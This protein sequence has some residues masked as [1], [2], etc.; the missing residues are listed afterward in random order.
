MDNI[1][2]ESK[3]GKGAVPDYIFP[4]DAKW[5]DIAIA[6]GSAP[7]DWTAGIDIEANLASVLNNPSFKLP[8]KNQ[9][10][11]GS[12]GGQAWSQYSGV[13]EAFF[14]KTFEERSAKYIYSQT[15][16]SPDGGSNGRDNSNICINQG[17]SVEV[18]CPS[19]D[20]GQ[21]PSE[22]YME[23]P[24]DITQVARTD[25]STD[26]ELSAAV[27][28]SENIDSVA[29]AIR[30]NYGCVLGVAGTNNGTWLSSF[31]QPPNTTDVL[32]GHWLYAGKAKMIDGKKYIGVINSWG[33]DVGENGW[34]WLGEEYFN[35][36]DIFNVWTMV[37]NE[38]SSMQFK[39]DFLVNLKMGDKSSE[40]S[41]LQEAL[42]IDGE[43][44]VNP[45]GFYGEITRQS[46]LAF[47][48]KYEINSQGTNGTVVGPHTRQ[49]LNE[50]FNK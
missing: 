48:K 6:R 18:L 44:T 13:L 50:I 43:F 36:T 32:W 5:E 23:R 30:D 37:F 38:K 10:G 9:N 19:Y 33:A 2:D 14:D 22:S 27:V 8:V 31:P 47:Q 35:A 42:K 11:S 26:R 17:V 1:L 24:Q 28:N 7:F 45:T 16:V 20:N 4:W 39:H 34:Q 25:A 41:S 3:L 12:C 29:Q 21:P 15:F 49:K 46:V 40:V